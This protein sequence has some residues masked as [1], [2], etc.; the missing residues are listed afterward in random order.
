MISERGAF[1][2]EYGRPLSASVAGLPCTGEAGTIRN[3]HARMPRGDWAF[4]RKH[5]NFSN[6]LRVV[7]LRGSRVTPRA[8][9]F[10]E[11]AEWEW[12]PAS[13]PVKM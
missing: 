6:P 4:P 2:P 7:L 5:V 8:G 11:A 1:P 13:C 9:S 3:P 12:M 10:P